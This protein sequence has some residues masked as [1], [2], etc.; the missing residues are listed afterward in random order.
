MLRPAPKVPNLHRTAVEIVA[1]PRADA[2]VRRLA[3][4]RCA[5]GAGTL[6]PRGGRRPCYDLAMV[7]AENLEELTAA[8]HTV[9]LATSRRNVLTCG[10][11]PAALVGQTFSVGNVRGVG[12]RLCAPCVHL[13]RV[14]GTALLRPLV[15]RGELQST[16]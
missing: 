12:R 15:H 14:A 4:D 13:D 10:I 2:P 3:I 8:G 5:V 6:T 16:G 7:A 9:G 11:D 1:A